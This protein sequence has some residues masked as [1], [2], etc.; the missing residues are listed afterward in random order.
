[1]VTAELVEEVFSLRCQVID[2]PETGTPLV[3]P[4]AR[5]ARAKARRVAT[6]AS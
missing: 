5:G 6:E 3:V 1:V 4:A 2:D